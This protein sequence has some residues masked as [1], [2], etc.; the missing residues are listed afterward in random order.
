[1]SPTQVCPSCGA[2]LEASATRACPYCGAAL[3]PSA[4]APTLLGSADPFQEVRDLARSG[5]KI[6]AIRVYREMTGTGLKEAKEAVE[7]LAA[8]Q[9]VPVAATLISQAPENQRFENSAE[10]VDEVKRLLRQ[11]KKIAA[12]KVYREYF[13]VGLAEAKTAVDQIETELKFS[14]A[15]VTPSAPETPVQPAEPTISANPF[16]AP[17][18]PSNMRGWVIGCSLAAL[19][20]LCLCVGL[21]L[22]LMALGLASFGQ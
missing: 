6:D 9:A 5:L 3:N 8:G 4:A 22:L 10:M 18:K 21:P 7:A 15:P 17:A 19:A 1:M 2:P 12:V 20:S 16:D 11:D 13:E 14:A